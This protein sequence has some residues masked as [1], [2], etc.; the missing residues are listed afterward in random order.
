LSSANENPINAEV[1]IISELPDN[2]SAWQPERI[3]TLRRN[4]GEIA[5]T[6]PLSY[7]VFTT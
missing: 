6:K 4:E 7:Y 1:A 5:K 3:N 2:I